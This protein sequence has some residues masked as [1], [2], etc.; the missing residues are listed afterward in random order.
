MDQYKKISILFVIAWVVIIAYIIVTH[1]MEDGTYRKEILSVLYNLSLAIIASVI[2][3]FILNFWE[4]DIIKEKYEKKMVGYLKQINTT[5]KEIVHVIIEEDH[6]TYIAS[7][8]V[9]KDP[10]K[11]IDIEKIRRVFRKK[12]EISC[13]KRALPETYDKAPYIAECENYINEKVNIIMNLYGNFIAKEDIDLLTEI[14]DNSIFKAINMS[15]RFN[16]NCNISEDMVMDHIEVQQRVHSRIKEI[17]SYI[18]NSNKD[19]NGEIYKIMG[20]LKDIIHKNRK[21]KEIEIREIK[22]TDEYDE[23]R[24]EVNKKLKNTNEE[25]MDI[26][27]KITQKIYEKEKYLSIRLPGILFVW[28]VVVG[29]V[30]SIMV[31]IAINVTEKISWQSIVITNFKVEIV[32]AVLIIALMILETVLAKKSIKASNEAIEFYKMVKFI[33]E[34]S[35]QNEVVEESDSNKNNIQSNQKSET[36]NKSLSSQG[37]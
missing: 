8:Q 30:T 19:K 33:L 25:I 34:N 32:I 22:T 31:T 35:S 23:L 27:N 12:G 6:W 3:F 2:F 4:E 1:N 37:H 9:C 7:A 36:V 17:D 28:G 11:D 10:I 21:Y 29:M 15:V 13:K 20:K 16:M 18:E 14:Q 26:H 5:M 24:K